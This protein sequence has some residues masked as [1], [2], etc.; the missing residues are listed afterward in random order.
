MVSKF[1]NAKI[2]EPENLPQ[3]FCPGSHRIPEG[4][5]SA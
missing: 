5:I 2:L 1:L 3:C 4:I